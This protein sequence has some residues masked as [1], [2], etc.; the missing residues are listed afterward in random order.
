MSDPRI[1]SNNFTTN[2][3]V[4]ASAGDSLEG[5][6]GLCVST[7]IRVRIIAS[8]SMGGDDAK[9]VTVWTGHLNSS[10]RYPASP[11]SPGNPW[12]SYVPGINGTFDG[13]ASVDQDTIDGGQPI[14]YEWDFDINFD[15]DN[16]GDPEVD[17]TYVAND[18]EFDSNVATVTITTTH[19]NLLRRP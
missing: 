5:G 16:D 8:D 1:T 7:E 6:A 3:F 19:L 17:F 2:P 11:P 12:M 15:S 4:L 18:G 10:T 14:A 9:P 13:T